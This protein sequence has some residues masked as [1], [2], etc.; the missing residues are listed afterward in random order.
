MRILKHLFDAN[1]TW[2]ERINT[3]NPDFFRNFARQLTPEYL[4]IGCS[5][6][7]VPAND[8]RGRATVRRCV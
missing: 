7:R 3:E 6:S 2:A 4:W 5:D 8:I 1:S